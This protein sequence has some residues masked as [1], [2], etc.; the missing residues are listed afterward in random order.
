MPV[1]AT[2]YQD[3]IVKP[4]LKDLG[5]EG[6]KSLKSALMQSSAAAKATVENALQREDARYE[7]ESKEKDKMPPNEQV[8]EL[9]ASHLNLVAAESIFLFL[10]PRLLKLVK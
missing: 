3:N 6:S 8:A 4:F 5:D 7:R 2:H 1:L 9:V 10:K